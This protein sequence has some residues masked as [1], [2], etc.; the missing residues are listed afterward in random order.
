MRNADNQHFSFSH[1][2]SNPIKDKKKIIIFANIILSSANAFNLD[3]PII[4][5]FGK[6]LRMVGEY[7]P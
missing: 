3:Q 1:T 4:F 2:V 7:G 6:E 5:L